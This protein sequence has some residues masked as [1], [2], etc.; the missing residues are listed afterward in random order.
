MN[1]S[2]LYYKFANLHNDVGYL[3]GHKNPDEWDLF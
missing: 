1:I 2:I 3:F